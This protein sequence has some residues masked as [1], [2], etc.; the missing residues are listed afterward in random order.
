LEPRQFVVRQHHLDRARLA[1]NAANQRQPFE[2]NDHLVD[3][4][5]GD[6]EEALE[7]RLGGGLRFSSV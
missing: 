6:L 4:R 1:W 2:R 3:R 7:V 5:C